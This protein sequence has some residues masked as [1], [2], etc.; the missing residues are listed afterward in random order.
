MD[1]SIK[2]SEYDQTDQKLVS[3]LS[4]LSNEKKNELIKIAETFA[5]TEENSIDTDTKD[6]TEKELKNLL[7]RTS[8]LNIINAAI[9]VAAYLLTV[10]FPLIHDNLAI[11]NMSAFPW[12]KMVGLV[13]FGVEITLLI[14]FVLIV[15]MLSDNKKIKTISGKNNTEKKK[16]VSATYR[17]KWI[18]EADTDTLLH[19]LQEI[20]ERFK[21]L[22]YSTCTAS[23]IQDKTLFLMQLKDAITIEL[24]TRE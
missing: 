18:K 14:F 3:I 20:E 12:I 23:E 7:F 21:N 8:C 10:F 4:D 19:D 13:S 24:L 9:C 15:Y 5:K 11:E 22:P 1:E 2:T 16:D 17:E 6:S